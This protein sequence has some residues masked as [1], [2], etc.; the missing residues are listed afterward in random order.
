MLRRLLSA[1]SPRRPAAGSGQH[2]QEDIAALER[3]LRDA[4]VESRAQLYNR[5]GDL[6][7]KGGDQNRGMECYGRATDTYLETGYFDAAGAMCRKMI[8]TAPDVVRARC[9]L[10]FLSLG[11]GL[12][13]DAQQQ[14]TDYVRTAQRLEQEDL[15]A[16]R[17]RLMAEA[18]DDQEVRL[19]L[20]E[21]LTE[22]G[23]AAGAN[24]VF[25]AV[26][27]ERNH[28]SET[29]SQEDQRERW[30]RVLRIALA[31]P[32]E[33]TDRHAFAETDRPAFIEMD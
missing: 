4:P 30:A 1:F 16:E 33:R 10:A 28:L 17:L 2:V 8:D 3:Q 9:T 31:G 13:Q 14:I 11:K 26:Y 15:A 21:Y 29:L 20:G 5:L 24:A 27:A 22:L 32:G 12:V 7:M 23:D 25:G 19:L 18:T 6:H